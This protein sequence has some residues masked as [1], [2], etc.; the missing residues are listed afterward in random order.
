MTVFLDVVIKSSLVL[1]VTFAA[2][3]L[4]RR[5]SAATRH[6]VLGAG[7]TCTALSPALALV[8]PA[9]GVELSIPAPAAPSTTVVTNQVSTETIVGSQQVAMTPALVSSNS[10]RLPSLSMEQVLVLWGAGVAAALLSL[11][12][13]FAR[14]G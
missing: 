9:W 11:V 13:G 10:P 7:L 2:G 3:W 6:F 4:L 8:V 5:S 14:L 12:A 1:L